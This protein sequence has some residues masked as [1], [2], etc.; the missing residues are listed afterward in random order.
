MT[1]K[2]RSNCN[3]TSPM[4]TKLD[5]VV[6][7]DMRP[8]LKNRHPSWQK[9]LSIHEFCFHLRIIPFISHRVTII[10]FLLVREKEKPILTFLNLYENLNKIHGS[11]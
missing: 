2:K 6:A 9:V 1:N 10:L 3:S 4:D 5:K 7:Y 11:I 8:T